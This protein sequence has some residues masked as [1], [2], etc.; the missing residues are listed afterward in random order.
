MTAIA[1]ES[2]WKTAAE[3]HRD[4][5]HVSHSSLECFRKSPRLYHRLY[6]TREI[7]P[8]PPSEAMLLGS[9]LH[10][11]LLERER[12]SDMVAVRPHGIDRRTKAGK[13]AWEEFLAFSGD[14]IVID[15]DQMKRVQAMAD[16]VAASEVATDL[17]AADGRREQVITWERVDIACK[18]RLDLLLDAGIVV[19]VKTAADPSPEGFASA[20]HRFGYHR[21][22]A[23]YLDGTECSEFLFIAIGTSEPYEVGVYELDADSLDLGRRQNAADLASLVVARETGCWEQAWHGQ[24]NRLSLPRYAFKREE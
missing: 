5:T 4:T 2:T 24:I 19:D 17:L 16:G 15:R 20:A 12:F 21:Q 3:Y 7:E 8:E 18:A 22:A 13:A 9:A 10:A 6:V 11:Y 1:T 14:K 23:W